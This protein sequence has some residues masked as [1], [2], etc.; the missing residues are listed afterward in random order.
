MRPIHTLL[1]T[2]GVFLLLAGAMWITP[3]NGVEVGDLTFHMPTFKEMLVNEKV[4]YADLSN[5]INQQFEIDSLVDI[6]TDLV[7]G[8]GF[9]EVVHRT[10]YDSLVQRIHK[11]EMNSEGRENLRNFFYHLQHDSLTRIMRS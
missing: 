9:V 10:E 4:E 11:L 8:N 6:E 1:F 7:K 3:K 5:I 2:L